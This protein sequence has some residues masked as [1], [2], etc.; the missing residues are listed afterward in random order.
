[1]AEEKTTA[2]RKKSSRGETLPKQIGLYKP[3][4]FL[5]HGAM[6][7]VY[8]CH[9]ESLNRMVVVKQMVPSLY[10]QHSFLERFEREAKILAKLNHPAIVQPYALWQ[11]TSG[12]YSLAMEFVYG[13]SLRQLLDKCPKPPMWVILEILY[14]IS[15]ALAEAHRYGV[16][17]RDVK[18]AN[19]MLDKDGRVR[20]LDFGVAHDEHDQDLTEDFAQL[21]T[22]S[23]MS[24]EQIA[25]SKRVAP[26]SDIFALGIIA[27]EMLL[28]SN[29]F[30][31]ASLAETFNNIQK[32][33][34]SLK[35][36]G[37]SV[38]KDVAQ[39]VL[40]MLSKDPQKRPLANDVAEFCSKTM[41]RYPR[42]LRPYMVE[43]ANA[44]LNEK[45]ADIVPIPY[46]EKKVLS[47]KAGLTAG[48]VITTIIA[49]AIHLI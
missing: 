36:F 16:I 38:P 41:R 27:T 43:W 21:G 44:A 28:G 35:A 48:I 10:D 12:Q 42:D 47:F 32:K 11:E 15:S 37:E 4:Q 30:R 45:E 6:G 18:P 9:D 7:N 3:T 39:F 29:P 33:K 8:L 26:G 5:G 2:P 40:T 17:H 34:P 49:I 24:P 1:M 13:K 25:D 19:I 46:T 23:Y 20:L 22:A 31:G 14:N